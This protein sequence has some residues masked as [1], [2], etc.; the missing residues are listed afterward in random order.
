MWCF[1]SRSFVWINRDL[2]LVIINDVLVELV[3]PHQLLIQ[4]S[5]NLS[6]RFFMAVTAKL[7]KRK[8]FLEILFSMIAKYKTMNEHLSL[9]NIEPQKIF[10][11]FKVVDRRWHIAMSATVISK[12]CHAEFLA[13]VKTS[14]K[15]HK[16]WSRLAPQICQKKLAH[17][18]AVILGLILHGAHLQQAINQPIEMNPLQK[19]AFLGYFRW[20]SLGL[21]C[22][23]MPPRP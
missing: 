21:S 5:H 3:Q 4:G 23:N 13:E 22:T 10:H 6:G 2:D 11:Q 14:S 19:P 15:L 8:L 20:A 1:Y 9:N 17:S 18:C 16:M 12:G 7:Q